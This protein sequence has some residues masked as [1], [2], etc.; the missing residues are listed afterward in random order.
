MPLARDNLALSSS[1]CEWPVRSSHRL[2]WVRE[3]AA[4]SQERESFD[5]LVVFCSKICGF[6]RSKLCSS[7]DVELWSSLFIKN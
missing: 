7:K 1:K 6:K 2:P 4:G 5:V 3:T